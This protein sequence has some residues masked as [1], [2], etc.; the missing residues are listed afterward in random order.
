MVTDLTKN[1]KLVGLS[2]KELKDLLGEPESYI[3]NDSNTYCYDI[4]VRY[5]NDIG[6]VYLKVLK[7]NFNTHSTILSFRIE[8]NF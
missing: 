5:G 1:Y 7:F 2:C 4:D 3:S 6:P 8:E